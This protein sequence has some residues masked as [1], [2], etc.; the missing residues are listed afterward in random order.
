MANEP[1]A[2]ERALERGDVRVVTTVTGL[3]QY[4]IVATATFASAP[5]EVWGLLWDWERL[6]VVGLPGM[7]SDFKW[8]SGGP[9]EVPSTFQF[10]VAG[11]TLKEEIYERTAEE[12][13]GRY[14]LRYR[15]LEPALGV[16]EYDALL[17]LQRLADA[18]TAFSATR[19]V[20]LAPGTA[21]D[22]LTGMVEFETQCLK[23]HFKA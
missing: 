1:G 11:A 16:L 17:E 14:R 13:A 21:P 19:E 6:V 12:E 10:D 22:M 18:L 7:T 2:D 4:R 15:A 9:D 20:R 3:D 23:E 8:L 5:L